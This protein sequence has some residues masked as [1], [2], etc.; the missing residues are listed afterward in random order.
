MLCRIFGLRR[1]LYG[2]IFDGP[3]LVVANHI[4]WLDIMLLHSVSPM[5]FVAKAEID[6]WP[7]AGWLAKVGGTVFHH[8]GSHDSASGV[9]VAMA[10]RLVQGRK[11]AIFPEGGVLPGNHVKRFHARLF[12]TSIDT[13]SPVQPIMLRYLRDGQRYD[14]I[15]FIPGESFLVNFFRLL[16]Q[17]ACTAQARILPLIFPGER[18]RRGLAEE[19]QAAV[20]AAFDSEIVAGG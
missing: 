3:C 19:A 11:V 1:A 13:G 6:K 5:G 14:D 2:E 9:A 12:A 20:T 15:T 8:R 7:V 17:R 16:T 10:E 18:Q 4:S